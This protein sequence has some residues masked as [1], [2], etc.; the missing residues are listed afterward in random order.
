MQGKNNKV[1]LLERGTFH[2]VKHDIGEFLR[3]K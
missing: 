2:Y 1:A 3:Y